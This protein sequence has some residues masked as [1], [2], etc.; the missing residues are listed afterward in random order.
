MQ[1]NFVNYPIY[2]ESCLVVAAP[3]PVVQHCHCVISFL[4]AEGS[5]G[6]PSAGKSFCEG[7]GNGG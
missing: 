3:L 5:L 1:S 2:R 7:G 6:D 4:Q